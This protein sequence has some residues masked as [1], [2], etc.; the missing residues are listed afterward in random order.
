[1]VEYH[2]SIFMVLAMIAYYWLAPELVYGV[3]EYWFGMV[4]IHA[5]FLL[6]ATGATILQ[7][8]SKYVQHA[9]Q[10]AKAIKEISAGL[11][12]IAQASS[13]V[14]DAISQM[15]TVRQSVS[16][17]AQIMDMLG[18]SSKKIGQI[19]G[20]ISN[21]SS[22]TNLLAL[23]A[24]IESA[25]AGE[26][27]K[28]FA[29]VASEVKK[30]AEQTADSAHDVSKLI[31]KIQQEIGESMT[32]MEQVNTE[33]HAGVSLITRTKYRTSPASANNPCKTPK[34]PRLPQKN[35]FS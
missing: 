29:V 21:I 34:T 15:E 2:F 5:S 26:Y 19:V 1:M 14:L 28:G 32:A 31:E 7:I 24:S 10:S 33:V 18:T 22:Q 6:L 20:V 11:R 8:L 17:F 35:S 16:S 30:L 13:S 27:G 3:S 12:Q 9:S 25:R 23:N 4:C